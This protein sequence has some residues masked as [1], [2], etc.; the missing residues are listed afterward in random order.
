MFIQWIL[1]IYN[2]FYIKCTKLQICGDHL[3]LL[4]KFH[5]EQTCDCQG[6]GGCGRDGVGGWGQ[7]M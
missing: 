4:L 5:R 1:S 3:D 6:E 7:Q 2:K